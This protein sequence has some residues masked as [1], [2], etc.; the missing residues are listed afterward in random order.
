MKQLYFSLLLLLFAQATQAQIVNIGDPNLKAAIL[1]TGID[2]NNDGEI[3]LSEASTLTGLN[4]L[5]SPART[6]EGI[7]HF[8]N[9]TNVRIGSSTNGTDAENIDLRALVNLETLALNGFS[10][11]VNLS[12]LSNLR[13]LDASLQNPDR[14]DITGLTSLE[15]F[16]FWSGSANGPNYYV[17]HLVNLRKLDVDGRGLTWLD[18]GNL[19]LLEELFCYQNQLT[20][21]DLSNLTNLSRLSCGFNQLTTLDI[22]NTDINGYYL[23]FGGN[24]ITAL[25]IH[26]GNTTY[27]GSLSDI[28]LQTV[29][30]DASELTNMQNLAS[31]AG[32]TNVTF[33]TDCPP[34][35]TGITYYTIQGK[36]TLDA[37]LNGCDAGDG[38]LDTVE[39]TI[40]NGVHEV[41][42]YTD[43]FGNYEFIGKAG[44]YTITPNIPNTSYYSFSPASVTVNLPA[45]GTTVIHDFC[46]TPNGAPIVTSLPPQLKSDILAQTNVD[47]NGDGEIQ[48]TEAQSVV[49]LTI[50]S[51]IVKG[52]DDFINIEKLVCVPTNNGSISNS[53]YTLYLDV[54]PL[55]NLKELLVSGNRLGT[56]DVSQNV[57]LET[58]SCGGNLLNS[59][60]LTNNSNLTHLSCGNVGVSSNPISANLNRNSFK[61]LD[62]SNNPLLEY[63]YCSYASI[64]SLILGSNSNLKELNCANSNLTTL[65]VTQLPNLERL[66]C[67]TY[68]RPFY[69]YQTFVTPNFSPN[70]LT[71]LDLSQN[72]NLWSLNCSGNLLNSLDTSAQ[73]ASLLYLYC[74]DNPLNSI[75]ISQNTVLRLLACD[76]TNLSTLDFSANTLLTTVSCSDNAL[77]TIDISQNPNLIRLDCRDN[78]ITQFFVKNGNSFTTTN[79]ENSEYFYEFRYAGNPVEYICAD[80]FE[81]NQMP[82]SPSINVNTYCSFTPGGDYYTIQG[83]VRFDANGNGCDMNDDPYQY[84]NLTV[85]NSSNETSTITTSDEGSYSFYAAAD[86]V[87]TITPVMENPTYFT[88]SPASITVDFPNDASPFT[89]NFCI[90]PNGTHHD[91]DVILIPLNTA[92]PGF[93]SNYKLVY[94]NKGNTTLSG[95]INLI[96]EDDFMDL[97]SVNPI[98]DSQAVNLLHWNYT[99][100]L[101]FESREI[102]FT[103]NLNTPTDPS[104]PLNADDI[105]DFETTIT[106]I[107]ADE[108]MDD[109][110]FTLAQTVVNSF[111]PNDKNCLQGNEVTTELIGKYVDYMIRFENTGTANAI[112]VVVKD[113]INTAMFDPAS[114]IVTN[115][116]HSV[117][118]RFT[119]ANTVEF[120]FE[121]INLPFDDAN[122]DG[123][124]TFKMK[125]LPTLMID[126]T[127]ENDAEIFFDYN[128]PIQTNN[129]IT[130]IK[131][132]LS[133]RDVT[134]AT[135]EIYPNPVKDR[136]TIQTKEA[137]ET[138]RMYDISGKFIQEEIITGTPNTIQITTANLA[139][140][141][142]FVKIE[143]ES[144]LVSVKKLVKG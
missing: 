17:N 11:D 82:S 69:Y 127:F 90:T 114:L 55:V 85:T 141:T 36:N 86:D 118:T 115:A 20:E 81:L 73:A 91:V 65:D 78:Q 23:G 67:G 47:T 129:S 110:T 64:E 132:V 128:F 122:N 40:S 12:G 134:I 76:A 84:L 74:N 92:R 120:I 125:T 5:F 45:D 34:T 14:L 100:L 39:Y 26:D 123:Y 75:D 10:G 112:N 35:P 126:D 105:L 3:Q 138:I 57:L 116:S 143:T 19:T 25:N 42:V 83:V 31:S 102:V 71:S 44:T 103:M 113:E 107:V 80:D 61:T 142:Y 53:S 135:F 95:A 140:G 56:L 144:G 70:Q 119:N 1:N 62:L 30:C 139:T 28:N 46:V 104:F 130:V 27:I 2:A 87:Y 37:N 111:D 72:P 22:S 106:P 52:L 79:F 29:C 63:V 41:T 58:L 66:D 89:Q 38:F 68:D 48:I 117:M 97:V 9:L 94:K 121:N 8:T 43:K 7:G 96:F 49:N 133:Q 98:T 15:E 54:K 59:L 136:F 88:V 93:D 6:F 24:P 108:T 137:I 124:V 101:P 13:T 18:V 21:L 109:N 32:Y 77:T 33:E 4:T 16:S 99:N 50:K 60:I 51:P 131:D